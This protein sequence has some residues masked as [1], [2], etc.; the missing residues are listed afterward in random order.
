[1]TPSLQAGSY[2][3]LALLGNGT[4][5]S[6]WRDGYDQYKVPDDAT[7]NVVA[8]DAG[9]GH[10]MALL[11]NGKQPYTPH[12]RVHRRMHYASFSH[13]RAAAM[14]AMASGTPCMHDC[15]P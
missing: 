9:A 15:Q 8:I 7:A 6:W 14:V 10:C 5:V 3:S 13:V 1:M 2:V 4:V 11:D 12:V